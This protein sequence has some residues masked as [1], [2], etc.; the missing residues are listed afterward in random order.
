MDSNWFSYVIP[1]NFRVRVA[2][3]LQQM[4]KRNVADAFL[5]CKYEHEDL[6]LAYSAGMRGDNWDKHAVDVTLEGL[7]SDIM[8]LKASKNN[9]IDAIGKALKPTESGFLIRNLY[10][11][12]ADFAM[13]SVAL[14][15]SNEMRL[16]ADIK[17]AEAV[18][19][20]LLEIGERLCINNSYNS[21][22][23]EN[24]MNDYFRDM[25]S[26]D[27]K[28]VKDQTRHG[29]SE[30]G[31]DAGEVDILLSREGK[32]VAIFEG[33]KLDS[34]KKDYIGEHIDKAIVNYNALGTPTFVVA[35]VSSVNF[36]AF[37]D[38]FF[39]FIE[40]YAYPITVKTSLKRLPAPNAAAQVAT[41]ILTRDGYDFPVY[42]LA[43]NV[44]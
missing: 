43:L 44:G 14:P 16:K 32:E 26:R 40:N 25:L 35:Y 4:G 9:V 22:S 20:D 15:A 8:L 18:L 11:L 28:E 23:S 31:K 38:R 17:A 5:R 39:S 41:M 29:I 10:L 12:E 27:Y 19:S 30:K 3:F 24:S 7:T 21:A 36:G 33:L 34:V 6:G 42:F 13:E 2:Q 37:A 1:S